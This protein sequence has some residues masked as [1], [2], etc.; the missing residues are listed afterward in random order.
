MRLLPAAADGVDVTGALIVGLL[1]K[2]S[3]GSVA[4]ATPGAGSGPSV[5]DTPTGRRAGTESGQRIRGDYQD[6]PNWQNLHAFDISPVSGDRCVA[7]TGND[8]NVFNWV[9]GT[10][11]LRGE[12]S[13]CLDRA[14]GTRIRAAPS[15]P[16]RFRHRCAGRRQRCRARCAWGPGRPVRRRVVRAAAASG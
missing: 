3:T 5:S 10:G 15:S 12:E 6:I 4:A 11:D 8:Q 13:T 7:T 1:L 9:E 2:G 14:D 16:E